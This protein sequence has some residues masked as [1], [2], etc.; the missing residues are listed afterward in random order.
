MFGCQQAL[1]GLV[2]KMTEVD[3][4][5]VGDAPLPTFD[6]QVSLLSLPWIFGTTLTTIPADVPY[7]AA[8]PKRIEYWRQE[9]KPIKAFKV[10]IV[11]QGGKT[12]YC[13]ILCSEKFELSGVLQQSIHKNLSLEK[14]RQLLIA[15]EA[16]P[17]F[18][19][20]LGELEHHGQ[21]RSSS[22]VPFGSSVA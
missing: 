22:A 2:N 7:L 4:L 6:V 10:G 18:L 15:M 8:D 11:W 3:K 13:Q 21:A 20:G 5:I 9:L 12:S 19:S 14:K 1:V 17:F 16:L